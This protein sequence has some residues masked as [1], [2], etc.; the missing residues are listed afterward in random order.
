MF[1]SYS[2]M[3]GIDHLVPV[4][5]YIPGCPPRPEMVLNALI[6]LQQTI[7]DTPSFKR[8]RAAGFLGVGEAG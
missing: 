6:H 5:Y 3:Q 2:V 8:T 7:K 1:R 4:D